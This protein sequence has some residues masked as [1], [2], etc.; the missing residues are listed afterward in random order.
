[1]GIRRWL[2]VR[3]LRARPQHELDDELA[4][5]IE[6]STDELRASGIP[7][8]DADVQAR[9]R[10]GHVP[11]I[12]QQIQDV[13]GIGL[14][15]GLIR[16]AR[17]SVRGLRHE[18]GTLAVVV[19]C[20]T[21]GIVSTTTLF[22]LLDGL[23]LRDVTARDASRLV[24]VGSLSWPNYRDLASQGVFDGVAAGGQ[25]GLRWRDR[26]QT[27]ALVANCLS[28]NFFAVIGGHAALGRTF[29]EE[30]AAPDRDPQV[31]ILSD[32][33]WR[34]LGGD[35]A[36]VGRTLTLN[37]K[38]WTIIGVLPS[39]YRAIQG[40]GVSPDV[41]VPYGPSVQ[42]LLFDRNAPAQDR[43]EVVGRIRS[44]WTAEQTRQALLAALR[45]LHRL[46]PDSVRDPDKE[47]PA[48]RPKSG[49]AKYG[50]SEYDRFI[51]RGTGGLTLAVTMM[52]AIACA[53]AA[54]L[55]LARGLTRGSA[56]RVQLALGASRWHLVRQL[57]GEAIVVAAASTALA[58]LA[59]R[60]IGR[61]IASV[62]IPVQDTTIQ[63]LFIHD[64]KLFAAASAAGATC[65]IASGLL[66][67][68]LSSGTDGHALTDRTATPARRAQSW[69]VTCQVGVSLVV[70]FAALALTANARAVVQRSPGFVVA[71]T[72]WFDLAINRRLPLPERVAVRDRLVLALQ[73]QPGVEAVSWAWYLPFQVSY[74]Q[75]RVR[76]DGAAGA[77]I[78]VIEQGIGPGYLFTMEIPLVD[79]REF[80]RS[81]LARVEGAPIPVVINEELA[82]RLFPNDRAVGQRL[83]RGESAAS[84]QAPMVVIG[85]SRSTPF[86]LAG[87]QPPP[88]L[89]SLSPFAASL[90]VRT[91]GPSVGA[92]ADISR[93]MDRVVPGVVAGSFVVSDRWRNATFLARAA[94]GVLSMLAASALV[95]ASI[96]L[97][98]LVLCNVAR[99]RREAA[100]RMAL[101]ATKSSIHAL[102]VKEHV[103]LV[104]TGC[105]FGAILTIAV[106]SP[107]T[108][109][110]AEGVSARIPWLFFG[111]VVVVLCVSA[112]LSWL[113]SGKLSN[114]EPS[115]ALRAD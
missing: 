42:P 26:D 50:N 101:G 99:R 55:M 91:R 29:T 75:P 41:F 11:R 9:R 59:L 46:H 84:G 40:Y 60:W 82:R 106:S 8:D 97:C 62:D 51:L 12:R 37:E 86:R 32:R 112:A 81:D 107:L 85:V 78:Q 23:V 39:D 44:K 31:V 13:A 33:F 30:E 18:R 38:P 108:Q 102:I 103:K 63:L 94:A 70:L 72:T 28:A 1:M 17:L 77:S 5:H 64:W 61:T 54:G 47:P 105:V 4:F 53:N 15:R 20:L 10:L 48:L 22:G 25:C 49:L 90:V 2:R 56:L 87:E 95:V 76:P 71:N 19:L 79:G 57:L 74:A 58:L 93:A 35:A 69:L 98:A 88:L 66:P 45:E 100:I 111:A 52:L 21:L 109:F 80:T 34:R 73:A 92:I 110:L 6:R 96:G 65:A 115:V 27:R 67:A 24:S 68:L 43:L 113:A 14:W 114:T 36:I 3:A 83:H 89:Q 7:P 16:D 104:A